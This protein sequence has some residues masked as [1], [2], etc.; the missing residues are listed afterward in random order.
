MYAKKIKA[1]LAYAGKTEAWLAGKLNTSPSAWNQR[2]KTEKFT[3]EELQ[4][5]AEALEVK[6]RAE[7]EFPDGTRI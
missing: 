5:I 7:F 4:K 6:F 3:Y 2:M 1:A